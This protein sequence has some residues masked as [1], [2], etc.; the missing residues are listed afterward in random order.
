MSAHGL[1]PERYDP[2]KFQDEYRQQFEKEL[3]AVERDVKEPKRA[4]RRGQVPTR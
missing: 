1:D 3:V 4:S 2:R